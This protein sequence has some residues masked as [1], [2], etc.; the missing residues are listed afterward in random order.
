MKT[1]TLS[2]LRQFETDLR[3]LRKD[4]KAL[5]VKTV[6]VKALRDRAEELANRW[7]EELRSPLEHKFKLDS[8]VITDTSSLMKQLHVLSRPSNLAT[9]YIKTLDEIL[10][11]YKNKFILPIQQTS[12]TVESVFD[13]QKL[14][15]GL[16]DPGESD[17]LKE[18]IDCANATFK[19]ASI[20]MGWCAAIDRIQKK[21]QLIGLTKFNATSTSMKNQTSGRFRLFT[22]EFKV[23]TLAE[24]Q[25]VFDADLIRVCEGMGL[26]DG[27][28]TDRLITVDFQWRNHSAH[29]GNAPIE[30]PHLVAF[31]TDINRIILTNSKFSLT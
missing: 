29:P 1:E 16:T 22:K 10:D 31:F 4:V 9:S 14:V 12:M 27:N 17:Y 7:V 30:D 24:L 18:A 26:F 8:Q 28:E 5:S 25:T 15:A 21:L 2:T 6:G 11:G 3:E 20:V 23:T 13:L 19:K